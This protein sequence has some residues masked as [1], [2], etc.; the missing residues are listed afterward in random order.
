[1]ARTNKRDVYKG[2][3]NHILIISVLR[4]NWAM[5]KI[6]IDARFYGIAGPGRYT[7]NI[8]EHLEK[9]DKDNKYFVFLRKSGFDQYIPKNKNFTKILA[10][11]PWYS[12]GEQTLFLLKILK[13]FPDLL[14]VPHFNIPVLYPG[15]LVVA[16]PDLIM[17]SY[18][19]EG[20]TT[21][22]KPYFRLK[23]IVYYG[24][25]FWALFRAKY[26]IVPSEV[27]KK[28]FM[29]YYKMFGEDKHVVAYEGIDPDLQVTKLKE[30]DVLK[31][32][33]IKKPYLFY[34]GSAYEHKNLMRL[35]DAYEML[36]TDYAIDMPLVMVGKPDKY[37]QKTYEYI[38]EK[39]LEDKIL[40]PGRKKFVND[41]ETVIL[42]KSAHTYIF[43]S[44]KEGFSL[45]PMESQYFK[46]PCVVSNISCH[47]EIYGD[48]V[49]YFDPKDTKDMAR[50]ID[51]TI[52]NEKLRKE[53]IERGLAN[54]EKYD[55]K[56]TAEI[57]SDVFNKTLG[58]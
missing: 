8:V 33:N 42:R 55:W 34:I 56:K 35:I 11:Y 53:L 32:Y 43:P 44:L 23:K 39:N 38:K 48:S 5:K 52:K 58:I 41:D 36:V 46:I 12:W 2:F 24:V 16:I 17:H 19:T 15:K 26:N 40:M 37:A 27:V 28:E 25:F 9:V 1:M 3:F 51:N 50:E 7:K 20:G 22:W 49:N 57:T 45:T 18:S 31:K 54:L 13:Y 6:A 14:Y 21:L 10:D 29:D 4:Y 47:K 30:K